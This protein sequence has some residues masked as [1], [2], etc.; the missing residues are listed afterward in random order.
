MVLLSGGQG[1]RLGFEH[2]KGIYN[3][4]LPSGK[5]LFE[6]FANKIARISEI[7]NPH[8]NAFIRTG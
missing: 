6:Y 4:E 8:V 3:I 7:G 1:S 2:P 5:S